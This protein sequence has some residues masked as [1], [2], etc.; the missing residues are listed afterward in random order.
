MHQTSTSG[1]QYHIACRK[2]DLSEYLLVPGDPDRVPKIAKLWDSAR[3]ISCRREFRSFTGEYKGVPISAIS[4]GIGPACMAIVVNEASAIG[5]HT[6]IR[7]GSSGAIQKGIGCGDLVISSAAVRLDGTSNCYIMPEYPAAANYEV[8]LSLIEAAESLG[9][10][11]YHVGVTATTSD[12]YAGQNRPTKTKTANMLQILQE[13]G[14]LNF[15]MEI[16]TLY[17]L[18]NLYGLRAGAVCAVY[19]NRCTGEFK[20][21]EGEENAIKVANK[22]VKI[23]HDW[24]E[25][26]KAKGKQWLFP[27]LI[28]A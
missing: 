18:A 10:N 22:A 16:A 1:K 13:A 15:E 26:K 20:P 3:E 23:L 9:I 27:S 7:V 2:G 5:A 21:G 14:V 6:F 4:S 12:F 19:A 25:K 28:R 11:N 24:D 8:L 17:T